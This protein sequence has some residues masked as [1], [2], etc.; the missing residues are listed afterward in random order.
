M[1]KLSCELLVNMLTD[2]QTTEILFRLQILLE[3]VVLHLTQQELCLSPLAP[4]LAA[5]SYI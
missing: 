4:H 3:P 2:M 5:C 1:L